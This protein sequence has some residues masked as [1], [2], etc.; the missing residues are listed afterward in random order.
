M[1]SV[2]P[3]D[4]SWCQAR[5]TQLN[6]L[7]Q[8]AQEAALAS[9]SHGE[10]DTFVARC[11]DL[12]R[13]MGQEQARLAQAFQQAPAPTHIQTQ[14]AQVQAG[15]TALQSNMAR[16]QAGTDRA[17][18]VLFPTDQVQTYSKLGAKA[19]GALGRSTGTSLK[20]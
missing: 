20:A 15:L 17:L 7:I 4:W 12:S 19:Y 11:A 14:L 5:L 9:L 18:G 13:V 2:K 3:V 1:A 16:L 6:D 10:T 8:K